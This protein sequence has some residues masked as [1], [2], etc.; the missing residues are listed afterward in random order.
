MEGLLVGC[1]PDHTIPEYY[2][3][4]IDEN[5]KLVI[6]KNLLE[7]LEDGTYKCTSV[8]Y[9]NITNCKQVIEMCGIFYVLLF[10]STLIMFIQGG[11]GYE[12]KYP[13]R[14]DEVKV[15]SMHTDIMFNTNTSLNFLSVGGAIIFYDYQSFNYIVI[16]RDS[17]I[18][19][20]K[21]VKNVYSIYYNDSTVK[22]YQYYDN[23]F[24]FKFEIENSDEYLDIF[25][26][27]DS[28]DANTEIICIKY[29]M[30]AEVHVIIASNSYVILKE[31]DTEI[32]I[33]L[34]TSNSYYIFVIMKGLKIELIDSDTK[35]NEIY[36]I[37]KNERGFVYDLL[38]T[39]LSHFDLDILDKYE[40]LDCIY[41][42]YCCKYYMLV[43]RN[44]QIKIFDEEC[45]EI[46]IFEN[47]TNTYK[48]LSSGGSYI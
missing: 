27:K 47:D 6:S 2:A 24:T 20:L 46:E 14:L 9:K 33:L 16:F 13:I 40:E 36:N 44:L 7:K 19:K 34:N 21:V 3:L 41:C 18:K 43:Q 32:F 17:N 4:I 25:C 31:T 15:D 1:S 37:L 8:D 35:A 28:A 29:S 39:G 26:G 10:D 30:Q 42:L 5:S 23:I 48:I 12:P 11:N 22:V 45:N 38:D